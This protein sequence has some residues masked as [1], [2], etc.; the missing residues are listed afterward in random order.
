MGMEPGL[1]K[2]FAD[3]AYEVGILG[4]NEMATAL[5]E[6]INAATP[7]FTLRSLGIDVDVLPPDAVR[8]VVDVVN[9]AL[10]CD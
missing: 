7:P 5:R 10:W 9:R 6:S 4:R 8:D 2:Q 1:A 3:H